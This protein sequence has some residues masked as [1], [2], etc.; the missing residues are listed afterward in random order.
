MASLLEVVRRETNW[1][2]RAE[3]R[4]FAYPL[5]EAWFSDLEQSDA[6]A[7][8]LEAFVSRFA[9]LAGQPGATS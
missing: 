1:L 6:A 7:E 8:T 2:R 9:R 4:L 5:D 3:R